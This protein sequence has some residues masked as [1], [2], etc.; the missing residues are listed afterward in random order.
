MTQ[1]DVP[2]APTSTIGCYLH[3]GP[4]KRDVIRSGH[5]IGR[6]IQDPATL[7]WVFE[8]SGRLRDRRRC[9]RPPPS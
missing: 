2:G 5:P 4:V 7:R 9:C 6:A 1:Y 8:S 3:A